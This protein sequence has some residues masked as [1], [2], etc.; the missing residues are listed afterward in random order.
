[1]SVSLQPLVDEGDTPHVMISGDAGEIQRSAQMAMIDRLQPYPIA[2]LSKNDFGP[3]TEGDSLNPSVFTEDGFRDVHRTRIVTDTSEVGPWGTTVAVKRYKGV[4]TIANAITEAIRLH[5]LSHPR[6]V[7]FVGVATVTDDDPTFWIVME[8]AKEDW[9]LHVFDTTRRDVND[10]IGVLLDVLDGLS[11]IHASKFAHLDIKPD[12]ILLQDG[13][14]KL[15]DFGESVDLKPVGG[16]LVAKGFTRLYAAPEQLNGAKM[17]ADD[18]PRCD[19]F[20]L[21]VTIYNLMTG[22]QLKVAADTRVLP[23]PNHHM[24][25]RTITG[26]HMPRD[27]DLVS[28][29]S[30]VVVVTG[31]DVPSASQPRNSNSAMPHPEMG[32]EPRLARAEEV[33]LAAKEPRLLTHAERWQV[34]IAGHRWSGVDKKIVLTLRDLVDKCVSDN[35][36]ERPSITVLQTSLNNVRRQLRRPASVS[37]DLLLQAKQAID[38]NHLDDLVNVVARMYKTGKQDAINELQQLCVGDDV[39]T[40]AFHE[41]LAEGKRDDGAELAFLESR[42]NPKSK[43]LI[44]AAKEALKYGDLTK[45][46]QHVKQMV[47]SPDVP[48]SAVRI[49]KGY[50]LKSEDRQIH[51]AFNDA[52]A[53][54]RRGDQELLATL[55]ALLPDSS[56]VKAAVGAV[57]DAILQKVGRDV[58][59]GIISRAVRTAKPSERDAVVRILKELCGQ[60]QDSY[61]KDALNQGLA[62]A[63]VEVVATHAPVLWSDASDDTPVNEADLIGQAQEAIHAGRAQLLVRVVAHVMRSNHNGG[64]TLAAIRALCIEKGD[65]VIQAAFNEGCTEGQ[66]LDK[67]ELQRLESRLNP[68]AKKHLADA[69]KALLDH[70]LGAL[71]ETIRVMVASPD[72]PGAAVQIMKAECL[73]SDDTSTHDAFNQGVRAGQSHNPTAVPKLQ[74]K[75]SPA[76]RTIVERATAAVEAGDFAVVAECVAQLVLSSDDSSGPAVAILRHLCVQSSD[77]KLQE[78]FNVGMKTA[79]AQSTTTRPEQGGAGMAASNSMHRIEWMRSGQEA[80]DAGDGQ[81]LV[82]VVAEIV[83]AGDQQTLEDVRWMCLHKG[84]E[85]LL[86]AFNEGC[87]E[88][89]KDDAAMLD[90]EYQRLNPKSKLLVE[91]A[92]LACEQGQIAQL[93]EIVRVMVASADVPS[94]AMRVVKGICL[95]Y[96][97]P[98]IHAAY[99]E[100]VDEGQRPD[101][102]TLTDLEAHLDSE[103]VEL[104]TKLKEA[105]AAGDAPTIQDLVAFAVGH[106]K[107]SAASVMKGL[108][109]V[110]GNR[111]IREA[112]NLGVRKGLSGGGD[113]DALPMEDAVGSRGKVDEAAVEAIR[114]AI[115][116][117]DCPSIVRL[118]G[119]LVRKGDDATVKAVRHACLTGDDVIQAAFNEGCLDGQRDDDATLADL[120]ARLNPKAK[121]LVDEARKAIQLGQTR[122]LSD[123]VRTMVASPDVPS[124]AVRLMKGIC[125]REGDRAVHD[126]FNHGVN[127]GQNAGSVPNQLPPEETRRLTEQVASLVGQEDLTALKN[128]VR[129]VALAIRDDSRTARIAVIRAVCVAAGNKRANDAYNEGIREAAEA[130]A[131]REVRD[132]GG[133]TQQPADPAVADDPT[134]RPA[135]DAVSAKDSSALVQAV[136]ALMRA[137]NHKA[138]QRVRHRCVESRDEVLQAA[139]NE[140]CT[141]G[142]MADPAEVEKIR[143]R[144]NPKAKRLIA[145]AEAAIAKRSVADVAELVRHMVASPDVPPPAV[146]V[147]KGLCL[148]SDDKAIRDAFNRGV[149]QAQQ[150]DL[151]TALQLQQQLDPGRQLLLAIAKSCIDNRDVSGVRRFVHCAESMGEDPLVHLV[152]AL[153]V[154]SKNG[155]IQSA[156]NE[157]IRLGKTVPPDPVDRQRFEAELAKK[158][159]PAPLATSSSSRA[160]SAAPPRPELPRTTAAR[161]DDNDDDHADPN[162][163]EAF[164]GPGATLLEKAKHAIADGNAT[165]L[166]RV[167]ARIVRTKD[168]QGRTLDT[169]RTLCIESND[170]VMQA[171]FNEGCTEGQKLDTTELRQY[172]QRLNPKSKRMLAEARAA[173]KNRDAVALKE[174]VRIMV[175]SPDIP[176]AAVQIVK[177]ECLALDI[178]ALHAAFNLGIREGQT[179]D[180]TSTARL[181]EQ[182]TASS[183]ALVDS[184]QKALTQFTTDGSGANVEALR[185]SISRVLQSR[186]GAATALVRQ[187]CLQAGSSEVQQAFNVS[188]REMA[189]MSSATAATPVHPGATTL[190][191]SAVPNSNASSALP[192][193]VSSSGFSEAN[194]AALT[195]AI[196][197]KDYDAFTKI[198]AETIRREDMPALEE[199]RGLCVAANDELLIAAFNEGCTNGQ[200]EDPETLQRLEAQLNPASSALVGELRLALSRRDPATVTSLISQMVVSPNL[201]PTAVRLARGLCLQMED[202]LVHEA[203]NVGVQRGQ[204]ELSRSGGNGAVGRTS[205]SSALFVDALAAVQARDSVRLAE[206]VAQAI[207]TQDRG[208]LDQIRQL[209]VAARDEILIAAFN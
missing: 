207:R 146:M 44:E 24:T 63:P 154:Q 180:P 40:A 72:I 54:S 62:G 8:S 192:A 133:V 159:P 48:S 2:R 92:R 125:L 194:R 109:V 152:K 178:S 84:D 77:R 104:V 22:M 86:A 115:A 171:A 95:N 111:A 161:P 83:R 191:E 52:V 100:G 90:T 124:T 142:Q 202:P 38:N 147:V 36:Q 43:R 123:L 53:D 26:G 179:N 34:P 158:T 82:K 33:Y 14:P 67:T 85:V 138:L 144:L 35:P 4:K 87:T 139:F 28:E 3:L 70:N 136:T 105:V 25:E 206:I 16:K 165:R 151:D 157:G 128:L 106:G 31:E 97:D 181:L 126:A 102:A 101:A 75:L 172:E 155:E 208:A 116:N 89:Q 135:L 6:V 47:T 13:R 7:D 61:V 186:D 59:A 163:V 98:A 5:T 209:C 112:F 49:V 122:Q 57:R 175:A 160:T 23:D 187:A 32:P 201:P 156:Y 15:A 132:G 79:L 190:A 168:G 10:V 42:L 205:A 114:T 129:D 1:M 108:C 121:K 60:S 55:E 91:K 37:S 12:N 117:A 66:K 197:E 120:E 145:D 193:A 141:L 189:G 170:D 21:G 150:G 45:F 148:Q 71:K 30:D 46:K 64:S 99:N 153:C 107:G 118:V 196:A 177:A 11:Y 81:A 76:T 149:A 198:V 73:D 131:E 182:L 127:E 183:R 169:V 203:F 20:A 137:Q 110:S 39:I 50:C 80:V 18:Y 93:K 78:A 41:G 195:T 69:R 204:E 143:S 19:I 176:G 103:S 140:G 96:E 188:L 166:V 29:R 173:M 164:L 56:E 74:E 199:I 17:T 184:F 94:S 119:D 51:S 130:Q 65:D 174:A 27:D 68:K 200:M 134:L 185:Q 167:V 9:S 58:L 113:P 162:D 88:G